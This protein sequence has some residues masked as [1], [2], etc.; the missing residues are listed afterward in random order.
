MT[1]SITK[2]LEDSTTEDERSLVQLVE[3]TNVHRAVDFEKSDFVEV[4]TF[5]FESGWVRLPDGNRIEVTRLL[6]SC[7]KG[8]D[9]G[10]Y[11]QS[12]RAMELWET[13]F[14][15]GETDGVPVSDNNAKDN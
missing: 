2:T 4:T 8:H 13:C 1:Y 3:F 9:H 15:V 12:P 11:Y 10:V 7:E 14:A 6:M 5:R